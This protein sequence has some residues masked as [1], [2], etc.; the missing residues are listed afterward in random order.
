MLAA[1]SDTTTKEAET[2]DKLEEVSN[3]FIEPTKSADDIFTEALNET[4]ENDDNESKFVPETAENNTE[5]P[6]KKSK[7]D[8][9][10]KKAEK[11]ELTGS[12]LDE[13]ESKKGKKKPSKARRIIT[14]VILLLVFGIIGL[15]SWVLL[16]GNDIIAKITGGRRWYGTS[17]IAAISLTQ[18][19]QL[20]VTLMNHSRLTVI[21]APT[22]LPSVPPVGI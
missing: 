20:L 18:L 15:V 3:S 9:K 10:S 8:K 14:V 13:E 5:E 16:W 7:K 19:A 4:I 11:I 6:M 2:K 17:S 1:F 12:L 22:F 21:N